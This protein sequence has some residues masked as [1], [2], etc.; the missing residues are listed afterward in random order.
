[1]FAEL[2]LSAAIVS[3]EPLPTATEPSADKKVENSAGALDATVGVLELAEQAE[4]SYMAQRWDHAIPRWEQLVAANPTVGYYWWRLGGSRLGGKQYEGAATAFAR[5]HELGVFQ[6]RPLRMAHHGECAWGAAAAHARLGNRDEALRWTRISLAD[7]LRD[8]RRFREKHFESLADD[9][10]FR[11]LVW[12]DDAKGLSRDDGLRRDLKFLMH[13]ARRI[14]YAPFRSTSEAEIDQL[15]EALDADIPQLNDEQLLVRL[16]AIVRRLGDGHTQI[17]RNGKPE[18]LGLWF[19]RL[20]DGVYVEAAAPQHA[21][22]VGAKVLKIGDVPVD[23]ALAKIEDVTS[24]DNEMTVQWFAAST[25]ASPAVLRG[26]GILSSPG[27]VP[28]TIEDSQGQARTVEISA[29]EKRLDEKDLVFQVPGCSQP[30]PRSLVARDKLYWFEEL[31]S[32]RAIYCQINGIGDDAREPFRKFCERLFAAVAAPEIDALIVDIRYN[33]GGNTFV[34]VPLIEG[35]IRSDKLQT[36]GSL[37]VVIG[38]NTFSAAQNTTSELERR[39]KAILVGEPT[40][41]NPNFIGESLRIPLPHSG[42]AVSLSD[43]WWQHSMAMDYRVWTNPQLFAPPTAATLRAHRDPAMEVIA[44]YR[45]KQ[46]AKGKT[47]GR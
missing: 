3:A 26:L 14:H 10:A 19:V 32:E 2:L 18:Q 29:L 37:F 35:I 20:A 21:D 34:N 44:H 1:M 30:L 15:V 28:L 7:G 46:S 17:R 40:G 39:T 8:I 27:P 31:P 22:L 45:A 36:P 23:E 9:V 6:W 38:R 24:R 42:W 16:M 13:E 33:G 12:Y 25:L 4:R 5:A 47:A 41:S 43:L 11:E